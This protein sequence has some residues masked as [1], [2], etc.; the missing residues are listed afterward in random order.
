MLL[1]NPT[2][3]QREWGPCCTSKRP[4]FSLQ[5][6]YSQYSLSATLYKRRYVCH[7]TI[8]CRLTGIWIIWAP[9]DWSAATH[10]CYYTITLSGFPIFSCPG[11]SGN[12]TWTLKINS[13]STYS[14]VLFLSHVKIIKWTFLF[15]KNRNVL[16]IS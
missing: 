9:S 1:S 15:K 16:D 8:F 4:V 12:S 14:T 10:A 13:Y 11:T 2:D 7:V 6:V 3:A 5:L